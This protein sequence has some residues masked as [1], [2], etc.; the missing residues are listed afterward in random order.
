[1]WSEAMPT[2]MHQ[3]EVG[4]S[5]RYFWGQYKTEDIRALV[6]RLA[7]LER[8]LI[9]E[10]TAKRNATDLVENR[11]RRIQELEAEQAAH[12]CRFK[13]TETRKRPDMVIDEED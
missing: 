1:M 9:G 7:E 3:L 10:R 12:I 8:V 11:T 5:W 2:V 13:I 6:D 4:E